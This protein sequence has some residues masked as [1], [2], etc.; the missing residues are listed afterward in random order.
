MKF[1]V[2]F[3][4]FSTGVMAQLPCFDCQVETAVR[5]TFVA[6]F[7]IAEE[8]TQ[9]VCPFVI[10]VAAYRRLVSAREGL[11]VIQSGQLYKYYI[12]KFF[13]SETKAR[14]F[15]KTVLPDYPEAFVSRFNG[16]AIFD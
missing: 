4:F 11:I 13:T 7:D 15:L 14:E 9:A 3:L 8:G 16:F 12:P 1:T 2:F 5:D 10:Q 6:G